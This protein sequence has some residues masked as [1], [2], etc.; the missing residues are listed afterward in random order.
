MD[1]IKWYGPTLLLAATAVGVMTMGPSVARHIVWAQS[2]AKI[3]LAKNE[4]A[5]NKSLAEMSNAFR[6]VAQAVEPSVVSIVV[7][8]KPKARH[9][10]NHGMGPG[11]PGAQ[12]P[13]DLLRRW[14]GPRSMPDPDQG[15]TDEDNSGP[16]NPEPDSR[17]DAYS[18]PRIMGNGSGWVYDEKGHIIT[19][20]HVVQ[21]AD[22]IT[23]RFQD[24]SEREGTVVGTDPKTDVAVIS[25]KGGDLHPASIATEVVQQ[26]DIVCAFGSPLSFEFS[27]SQGIVSAKGRQLGILSQ[28]DQSGNRVSG[29]ENFIQTDAA[30]NPGNSGGPLTNIRGE[31]VGMNSAI[32]SKTGMFS[33]LGFAIPVDMVINVADQLIRS[34]KVSRGYLG[35]LIRDLDPKMAKSFNFTGKGVLIESPIEGG[36]GAKAGMKDG[37]IITQL[38]GIVIT[39]SEE[40]RRYVAN[41]RP[42]GKIAAK[43]FRDGKTLDLTLQVAEQPDQVAAAKP[44]SPLP[45]GNVEKGAEVLRR[46][47]IESVRPLTEE[48]VT[49]FKLKTGTTGVLVEGVRQD[50]AAAAAGIVRGTIITDV[51]G[52]PVTKVD[53]LVEQLEAH[54][55]SKGQSVRIRVVDPMGARFVILDLPKD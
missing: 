45:Q 7:S 46:V 47:G 5:E 28:R 13:E 22:V 18:V 32:A 53:E 54:G 51:M 48:F 43:V 12:N 50:S 25:V 19:N 11:A 2:D 6:K 39:N 34:G 17:N 52:K 21:G 15:E 30:I 16:D 1:R 31:V 33:G 49:R 36:P 42:G 27:M 38:D 24:G 35:I 26:G 41:V 55:L 20:N 4:L 44:N 29:Y 3:V 40:L 8:V 10:N 14:F 37:D 23:V 9:I